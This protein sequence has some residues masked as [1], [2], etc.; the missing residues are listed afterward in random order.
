ML[1]TPQHRIV[2]SELADL[3]RGFRLSAHCRDQQCGHGG[4]IDSELLIRLLG[5][6]FPISGLEAALRGHLKCPGC[7]SDQV[8]L[9]LALATPTRP[10]PAP[11]Q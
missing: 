2:V 4:Y 8:R 10:P 1:S 11:P 9:R 7:G 6:Q 5:V 3:R